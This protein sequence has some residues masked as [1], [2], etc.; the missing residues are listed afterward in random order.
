MAAPLCGV[1]LPS[2]ISMAISPMLFTG[3]LVLFLLLRFHENFEYNC[4]II[5]E[6]NVTEKILSM[7][8]LPLGGLVMVANLMYRQ[9]LT[10]WKSSSKSTNDDE[11]RDTPRLKRNLKMLIQPTCF[12][13][14]FLG[15][16]LLSGILI[17]SLLNGKGTFSG[18]NVSCILI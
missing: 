3:D 4:E 14:L 5:L 9:R 11:E 7:F 10:P 6:E 12:I 15:T 13:A 8:L 2:N 1:D 18:F 16:L 17:Q